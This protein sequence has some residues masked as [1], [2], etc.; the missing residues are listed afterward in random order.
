MA[1]IAVINI[2]I[3][4]SARRLPVFTKPFNFFITIDATSD[5]CVCMPSYT[6]TVCQKP[7]GCKPFFTYN[8]VYTDIYTT[9]VSLVGVYEDDQRMDVVYEITLKS[10]S[11]K[12]R[13]EMAAFAM[14]A[15][16]QARIG[17][18]EYACSP[19]DNFLVNASRVL[20][21]N[22]IT[23]YSGVRVAHPKIKCFFLNMNL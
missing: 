12:T 16:C 9:S 23:V 21:G 14:S 6:G 19:S 2:F 20:K 8:R 22:M 17:N 15:D 4:I 13:V 7:V 10:Y 5:A 3:F 18:A 11:N 1:D